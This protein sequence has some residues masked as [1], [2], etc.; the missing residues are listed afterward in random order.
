MA[1]RLKLSVSLFRLPGW[2]LG[3]GV[4]TAGD[5]CAEGHGNIRQAAGWCKMPRVPRAS[6]INNFQ[7][8]CV[9][10]EVALA[11]GPKCDGI[12]HVQVFFLII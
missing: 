5:E 8:R 6:L 2:L 1:Q 12:G 4:S 3:C 10:E 7:R 11:L 9:V